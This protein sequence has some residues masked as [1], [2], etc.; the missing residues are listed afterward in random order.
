M[1][2][3]A[4]APSAHPRGRKNVLGAAA[5]VFERAGVG[6]AACNSQ[7][8]SPKDVLPGCILELPKWQDD[9]LEG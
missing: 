3:V 1:D 5:L 9:L 2:L 7:V 8:N 4:T 6:K